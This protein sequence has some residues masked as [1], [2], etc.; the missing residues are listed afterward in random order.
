MA[1]KGLLHKV[2][3]S[4]KSA[5][6]NRDSGQRSNAARIGEKRQVL[7]DSVGNSASLPLKKNRAEVCTE[8]KAGKG[9][10]KS[11]GAIL[12]VRKVTPS[13]YSTL[14][15]ST[16][17]VLPL[18]LKRRWLQG[19]SSGDSFATFAEGRKNHLS[20]EKKQSTG[21]TE[22]DEASCTTAVVSPQLTA[23][24]AEGNAAVYAH[25][26]AVM[27]Y[28]FVHSCCRV[29]KKLATSTSLAFLHVASLGKSACSSGEET[30]SDAATSAESFTDEQ[31]QVYQTLR[32]TIAASSTLGHRSCQVLWGPR[33]SG[34]HRILRLVAQENAKL[35]STL[36]VELHGALLAD[37]E[38]A[39]GIIADQMLRFLQ[40]STSAAVRASSWLLRTGTFG[41]GQLFQFDKKMA[42]ETDGSG[43]ASGTG[44]R[45]PQRS[46]GA[47]RTAKQSTLTAVNS[48]EEDPSS[49]LFLTSTTTY[50]AGG[51]S[52]ALPHLQRALLLLKANGCSLVLCIRDIDIFGIRCD[53][54]LYVLSGLMH[55]GDEANH[56]GTA[57]DE[58]QTMELHSRNHT[59]DNSGQPIM[60]GGMSLVLASSAPDIRH[61]EKRLSSRL[62]CEMRYVPLLPWTP[63]SMMRATLHALAE[64]THHQLRIFES[65]YDRDAAKSLVISTE[66]M[67]QRGCTEDGE[68]IARMEVRRLTSRLVQLR[69][70]LKQK[71]ATLRDL[72]QQQRH[73]LG[74][75][76]APSLAFKVEALKGKESQPERVSHAASTASF[77]SAAWWSVES[78]LAR[79]ALSLE[80]LHL[81]CEELLEEL[82]KA[83][84]QPATISAVGRHTFV[85]Q[86]ANM[87]K[88]WAIQGSTAATTLTAVVSLLCKVSSGRVQLFSRCSQLMLL[89]WLHERLAAEEAETGDLQQ[90]GGTQ[91][92]A[93]VLH[94]WLNAAERWKA[95]SICSDNV[96]RGFHGEDVPKSSSADP[97][98][99]TAPLA[100]SLSHISSD[101]PAVPP[102]PQLHDL[103]VDG[104]LI[105]LGYGSREAFL[106]LFYMHL[107][108]T[109][110][111]HQRTVPDLLEDVSS[112]L[113]TKAAA[114]LDREAFRLAIRLL[115]RWRLLRLVDANS[116][117]IEICGSDTRLCEFL[118]TVLTR[119][120][121]W[122]ANELGLDV[123]E[124]VRL[125]NLL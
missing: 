6:D 91:P 65:Q 99:S 71:E 22:I 26:L 103:L 93:A 27:Q 32:S 4:V 3:A 17:S 96:H 90:Q 39:I 15:A 63:R 16:T 59:K 19:C 7:D 41:F 21:T 51:A 8:Q 46:S 40:N 87:M 31:E 2:K 75:Y 116:Q 78:L 115:C 104:Q 55:D 54:L 86:I 124:L 9:A 42:V 1:P 114:A 45:A 76:D 37:D 102:P 100:L 20:S 61:L 29:L 56:G 67:L 73:L 101:A 60:P 44:D 23:S 105:R 85:D 18:S 12:P 57:E 69:E 117:A 47:A 64:N 79:P 28:S 36:V 111:I 58:H 49:G 120:Q 118:S 30:V 38:A 84:K 112:S 108:Y 13:S 97:C 74:F 10:K 113:G 11:D 14:S 88:D 52:S 109:N 33:G 35:N 107:H 72:H 123:R 43:D 92:P 53:Q 34:K 110:G 121:D 89:Q 66:A 82:D 77:A 95:D 125:R 62:T 48:G 94:S 119:A 68:T 83:S 5:R 122:C 81:F 98:L 106:L 24:V 70:V 25:F 50:L 80:V